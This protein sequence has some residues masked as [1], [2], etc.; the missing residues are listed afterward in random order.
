MP[1]SLIY[2][3][4]GSEGGRSVGG[5]GGTDLDKSLLGVDLTCTPGKSKNITLKT[6]VYDVYTSTYR[7]LVFYY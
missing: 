4:S 6:A 7:C 1:G 2:S 3:P 5:G